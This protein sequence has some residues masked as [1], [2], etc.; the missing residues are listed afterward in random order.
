MNKIRYALAMLAAAMSCMASAQTSTILTY[1]VSGGTGFVTFLSGGGFEIGAAATAQGPSTNT[2]PASV[3]IDWGVKVV[4][5]GSSSTSPTA[6]GAVS[7]GLDKYANAGAYNRA[8]GGS[9]NGTGTADAM[10]QSATVG[11]GTDTPTAIGSGYSYTVN[12]SSLVFFNTGSGQWT[13]NKTF[14]TSTCSGTGTIT[15]PWSSYKDDYGSGTGYII[16][17]NTNGIISNTLVVSGN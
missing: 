7:L 9:A 17:A 1:N 15:H 5:T 14:L 4:W 10:T 3:N 13:A 11:V 16:P 12:G 6:I 8:I 2:V